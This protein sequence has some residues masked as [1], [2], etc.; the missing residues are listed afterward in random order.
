MILFKHEHGY[1]IDEI[2]K[3]FGI[4]E[5]TVRRIIRESESILLPYLDKLGTRR[6]RG[7][8]LNT[9]INLMRVDKGK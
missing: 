8:N 6:I 3:I 4:G 1:R 5:S 9:Y 7:S 2:V